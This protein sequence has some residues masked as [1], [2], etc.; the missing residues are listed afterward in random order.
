MLQ[1]LNCNIYIYIYTYIY[2]YICWIVNVAF[3]VVS[4]WFE[5][6]MILLFFYL[7]NWFSIALDWECFFTCPFGFWRVTSFSF[8]DIEVFLFL[9]LRKTLVKFECTLDSLPKIAELTDIL[10]SLDG[11]LS[12]FKVTIVR[13][14]DL[15]VPEWFHMSWFY[16]WMATF[17]LFFDL[18]L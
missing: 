17:G 18:M 1:Q 14:V 9:R 12:S 5:I 10:L 16:R 8:Y 4:L 15:G 2:T 7:V 6:S 13:E 3:W 11:S